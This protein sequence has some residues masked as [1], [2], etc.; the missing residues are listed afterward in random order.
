MSTTVWPS[1]GGGGHSRGGVE[2]RECHANQDTKH[3]DTHRDAWTGNISSERKKIDIKRLNN[4][5]NNRIAS[6]I[7]CD[8][9]HAH[10]HTYMH[11]AQAQ[12]TFSRWQWQG[13][14][15]NSRDS[16]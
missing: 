15:G 2:L 1:I 8:H 9:T 12:G 5:N 11:I 3:T 4:N 14:A 10:A 13:S 16:T 7:S 6:N